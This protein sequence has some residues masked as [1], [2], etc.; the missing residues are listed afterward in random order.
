MNF[1]P[2][3]AALVPRH[4]MLRFSQSVPGKPQAPPRS[5]SGADLST[6][7]GAGTRLSPIKVPDGPSREVPAV[8]TCTSGPRPMKLPQSSYSLD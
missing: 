3:R 8:E 1:C 6:H 4:I 5:L 2:Y 7:P